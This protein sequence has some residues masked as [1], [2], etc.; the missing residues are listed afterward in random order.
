MSRV[1]YTLHQPASKNGRLGLFLS[2]ALH[3]VILLWIVVVLIIPPPKKDFIFME[4]MPF[5]DLVEGHQSEPE[6]QKSS[7]LE[8]SKDEHKADDIT[9]QKPEIPTTQINGVPED[10][11]PVALNT[12]TPTP[13]KTPQSRPATTPVLTS[14]QKIQLPQSTPQKS[15][16]TPQAATPKPAPKATPI[17]KQNT[18]PA[19][20]PRKVASSSSAADASRPAAVLREVNRPQTAPTTQ[21]VPTRRAEP[22]PK[23]EPN[24]VT[25]PAQAIRERLAQR[26]GKTGVTGPEKQGQ[27]GTR[28]P[29]NLGPEVAAFYAHVRDVYHRAWRQPIRESGGYSAVL[30][31]RLSR[32]GTV[33]QSV[34]ISPSGSAAMDESVRAAARNVTRLGRSVPE[35]LEGET[36]EVSITFEY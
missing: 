24:T 14:P 32:D 6:E 33:Q 17:P 15:Q 30:K 35:A 18:T 9:T 7:P 10:V 27:S 36:V 25:D 13:T 11:L 20:T 8:N 3:L 29:A 31:I 2:L 16:P 22:A 12:P 4:L 34:L 1:D 26:V 5:G 21:A 19:P 23:P 28:N